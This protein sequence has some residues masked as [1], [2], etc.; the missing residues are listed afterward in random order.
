VESDIQRDVSEKRSTSSASPDSGD[1]YLTVLTILG[2]LSGLWALF[3]WR[4]LIRSRGGA[5]PFCGF[6]GSGDCGALWDAD[7]A[8]AVHGWTGIPVAGWGVIWGGLATLLPLAAM[9]LGGARWQ[10]R[11]RAATRLTALGGVA[12]VGV[13]LGV[14]SAAGIFCFSCGLTYFLTL[15]YVGVALFGLG[16]RPL[17]SGTG[18]AAGATLAFYLLLLY[19]GLATPRRDADRH[20]LAEAAEQALD[21]AGEGESRAGFDHGAESPPPA[22][23]T[24]LPSLEA[25]LAGLPEHLHQ[26]L[27]DS[28]QIYRNSPEPA[29]V[30][31]RAMALGAPGAPVRITDF[32]DVLCSHC[33]TLHETLAY[34]RD[35]L[36]PWSFGVESRHFP[37]DGNC[38]PHI[39]RRG[40]ETVRCLAARAQI[41]LE[42]TGH[43]FEYS[44]SLFRVQASL[45]SEMVFQLA[46]P[47][48]ERSE[49]EGCVDSAETAAKL[50]DDLAFAW[51]YE[52]RGTPLVLIDGRQGTAFGPFL[53]AMVLAGGDPDHPAFDALPPPSPELTDH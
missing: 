26:G 45:T 37:L 8:A 4:E 27:A 18:V 49:L 1:R 9:T 15:A 42:G 25:F 50:A 52:P 30:E 10:A 14:S 51:H 29:G 38:N 44:G 39:T 21:G 28:L 33:A 53:Y 22:A 24:R 19:P 2:A 7:F 17:L 6:G 46:T 32:T 13:L 5:T 23:A 47:Y 12:G 34:L 16:S 35:T 11:A 43:A 40:P 3:L 48:V 31:P 36:P 20:G 41:C